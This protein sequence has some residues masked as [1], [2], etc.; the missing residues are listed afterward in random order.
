MANKLVNE[1]SPYLRQHAQN[2]VH[3]HPW[4][5]EAFALARE[6]DKPVFLSI[7]Y[8]TCHWCHVMA[9]E[10]F[11][12]SEVAAILNDHFVPVKV[13]R[14]ERPDVDAIY[15][16]A[17]Q[18]MTGQGGWPL[19]VFLTPDGRPFYAGTYFPPDI[20]YGRPGLKQLLHKLSKE[21]RQN[22]D[23]V[24]E[25]AARMKT[26]LAEEGAS[27]GEVEPDVAERCF[28]ALVQA[29]DEKCGGFGHPPKFPAPHNLMFLLRYQRQKRDERALSMVVATLENMISGGIWDHIGFGFARYSTDRR[30]LVPHF[31]KMLYDNALLL[32]ACCEAWQVSGISLF[33]DTSRGIVDW[34]E[35]E[36][37]APG[38]GFYSAIDADS[39]GE[40]GKYYL[41]QPS[42][43]ESVLGMEE[44]ELF[45][46]AYDISEEGNF[47]GKNIANTIATDWNG[48]A[49]QY[50]MNRKQLEQVLE[51]ARRRMLEA[52]KERVK[53][54]RDEK[55]LTAW[56]GLMIAGLAVGA[57]ALAEAGWL[58]MAVRAAEYIENN[59]IVNE[60]LMAAQSDGVVK[61]RGY[62]D[63]Y[64]CMLWAC[65][66]LY[67]ASFAP[68]WLAAARHYA[69]SI[70]NLFAGEEQ[71]GFYFTGWDGEQLIARPREIYDG[72]M[73]SGNSI[74]AREFVRLSRLTGEPGYL[75]HARGIFRTFAATI[76]RIP[77]GHTHL[78][79][80]LLLVQGPAREVVVIG[81]K[82][83]AAVSG[84]VEKLQQGF[85]PDTTLVV[86][87]DPAKLAEAAPILAGYAGEQRPV[88]YVCEN[89]T[90]GPPQRDFDTLAR[91]LAQ[92]PH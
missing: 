2:P 17:C 37:T 35:R 1:T 78:L 53:P 67:A 91:H 9:R 66:E 34:L 50:G 65:L 13:D 81:E 55:I 33:A 63:D 19:S 87:D 4:G 23:Q 18:A 6:K 46:R 68:R 47:A 49:Q 83:D 8:S 20:R 15:M 3:W 74:I 70:I 5:E 44:A 24:E 7:G 61:Y 36:M 58:K 27:P 89:Q 73:P 45:C 54:H 12:N 69:D 52:R 31:E 22:R 90:C 92:P 85:H 43:V 64:A 62:L 76:N 41:L 80:G 84:L 11:T 10:S 86:T 51:L 25:I 56:N 40:E 59:L 79:Q 32:I 30:W 38:G 75:E 28:H 29:F 39:E 82:G 21:Y 42:E 57:R 71:G 72:A 14:E 60:R 77:T 88:A 16:S 26:A 48:L